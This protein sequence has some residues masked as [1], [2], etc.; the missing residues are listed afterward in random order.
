MGRRYEARKDDQ[1]LHV[2]TGIA[3]CLAE[4]QVQC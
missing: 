4:E 3:A 2:D 1:L